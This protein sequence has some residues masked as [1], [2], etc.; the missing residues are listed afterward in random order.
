[1]KARFVGQ[2]AEGDCGVAALAMALRLPYEDVYTAAA[3][4]E[5]RWRGRSGLH[6]KQV[7]ATA[8]KLGSSFRPRRTWNHEKHDGV[9]GI[10]RIEAPRKAGHWVALIEGL[11]FDP[12]GEVASYHDY[13]QDSGWKPTCLLTDD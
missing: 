5:P 7:C 3:A 8:Q 13:F 4:V 11:V 1:V 2:R 12:N 9:L 6:A 10:V